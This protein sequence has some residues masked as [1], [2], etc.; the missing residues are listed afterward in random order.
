MPHFAGAANAIARR[1]ANPVK[2]IKYSAGCLVRSSDFRREKFG[3]LGTGNKKSSFKVDEEHYLVGS[4]SGNRALDRALAE[5]LMHMSKTFDILP[6]F[7]FI[8]GGGVANAF[9]TGTPYSAEPEDAP[10]PTR[11][12][13]TVLFGDNMLDYMRQQGVDNP[14]A[15]IIAVCAHEFG[16]IVQYNYVVDDDYV[17]DIL[18]RD[19]PTVKRAE[20]HADFLAGYYVGVSK[21]RNPNTPAA[22]IAHAAHVLGDMSVD[23]R[24]H[25][26]TPKER[27][28]AVFA[29][30]QHSFELK[31][32]FNEALVD[33]LIYVGS[34]TQ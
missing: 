2:D 11:K 3:S 19:Q 28:A 33:G 17:I 29:G 14:V 1:S 25:H 13:G 6:T 31:K 8:K 32:P 26:G 5:A 34:L 18:S 20:L 24:S 12:H 4:S 30:Y 10:L 27:G 16:H 7:G 9:A 21:Q 15:A 22:S 23:D